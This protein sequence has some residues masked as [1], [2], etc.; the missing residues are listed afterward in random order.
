[1][2]QIENP[3][4]KCDSL[5]CAVKVDLFAIRKNLEGMKALAKD[6]LIMSVVK[7]DAYGHGAIKVAKALNDISDMFAVA[8]VDEG[9]ELRTIGGIKKPILILGPVFSACDDVILTH[10]L[11][12][13]VFDIDRAQEI[14]DYA[15][16]LGNGKVKA[17]VH[18]AV[19]T[20]MS[21]IGVSPDIKGLE[22]VKK[23]CSL[24]N[25]SVDGIFTHFATADSQ[26][27]TYVNKAYEK[28]LNFRS[29]CLK[30]NVNIPIW[31]SANSASVIDGIGLGK[32]MNMV[33]CGI[34]MYGMYPSDEV[35]KENLRLT[36]PMEWYS[37]VT[38]INSIG[39]GTSIS[40]GY[41]FTADK[42]M[43]V[44]TICCG[45]ADGYPRLLSNKGT[46]LIKGKRCRILGRVCMDQFMIDVS[47]VPDAR[48]GDK[49]ILMGKSKDEEITP[50][51]IALACGTIG[52]EIVC[53]ISKRVPRIYI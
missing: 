34:S 14:N 32:E 5:R 49:V 1:M 15:K 36:Y 18:I 43:K 53:D 4:I 10:D 26:D 31:H 8:S 21:R 27:K 44:A 2:C 20:G 50:D 28:F 47:D 30:S 33:R 23:I 16:S 42:D 22:I 6:K 45:Y 29:M 52:Y 11:T 51:E 39:P 48:V 7:A 25:I 13:T 41:S 40:Y 46:V 24:P 19:D 12:Q 9:V 3:K 35:H 17:K 38:R 37:F